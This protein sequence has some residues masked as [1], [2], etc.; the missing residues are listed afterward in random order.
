MQE[1]FFLKIPVDPILLLF[2]VV[3]KVFVVELI[4]IIT[5]TLGFPKVLL[6]KKGE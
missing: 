4:T 5:A 2:N 6:R 3:S 1:R